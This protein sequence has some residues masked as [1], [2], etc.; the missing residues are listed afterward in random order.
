MAVFPL[1]TQLSIVGGLDLI[2]RFN[3]TTF[4]CLSEAKK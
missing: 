4:L 3:P 2:N 1:E